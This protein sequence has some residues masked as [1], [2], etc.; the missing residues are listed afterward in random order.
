MSQL[1]GS[2]RRQAK[3]VAVA[4]LS[5]TEM[6][7]VRLPITKPLA[8]PPPAQEVRITDQL[9]FPT[10]TQKAN[11]DQLDFP[12]STQKNNTDQLDYI[13]QF[14]PASGPEKGTRELHN[15][16]TRDLGN[17]RATQV[18]SP[19]PTQ[20][21]TG[22]SPATMAPSGVRSVVVIPGKRKKGAQTQ[23]TR[24]MHPHLRYGLIVGS[25]LGIIGLALM[26]FIPL[27]N[28]Q[29]QLSGFGNVVRWIQTQQ[30]TWNLPSHLGNP[31]QVANAPTNPVDTG[32]SPPIT[33]LPTSQYIAI[34]T[35]DAIN[36]GISPT[37]FVNQIN[38]ESSFNPNAISPAGAVG[39]AQ[40]LPSTAAGLGINPYD[41]IQA[42]RGA[43]LH[44][45]DLNRSYAGNYAKALAAYNA[46]SGAVNYAV[47]LGGAN[48]MNFVPYETQQY[49]YKI[50]GV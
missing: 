49:I 25:M 31:Q 46:G 36:V 23:S 18:L 45:A 37:Y 15:P 28:D 34:A 22:T 9:D 26:T 27:K 41:P 16:V 5:Y 43:A 13:A 6:A 3:L 7:T 30:I 12:T 32:A 11:T 33:I 50:M 21:L 35:Q 10:S 8:A 39:I 47:Q 2:Q 42:L 1:R 20:L 17:V 40:F 14:S 4:E 44:M 38:A 48:W 29:N 24:R 19:S